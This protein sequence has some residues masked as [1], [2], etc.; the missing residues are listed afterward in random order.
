MAENMSVRVNATDLMPAWSQACVCK[1]F[2][3]YQGRANMCMS[4]YSTSIWAEHQQLTTEYNNLIQL[5]SVQKNLIVD[6]RR[7][8]PTVRY[9]EM[10]RYPTVGTFRLSSHTYQPLSHALPL[11][12]VPSL[13][14]TLIVVGCGVTL[15]LT[16]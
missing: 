2:F 9:L 16:K 11:I 12:I 14:H 13:S 3:L 5:Y 8:V 1:G 6:D 4:Q 10:P 15:L 7:K